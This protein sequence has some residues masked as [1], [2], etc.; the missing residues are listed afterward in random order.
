LLGRFE[1]SCIDPK[2]NISL[3]EDQQLNPGSG[4][5]YLMGGFEKNKIIIS[6][7][8]VQIL[9]ISGWAPKI[10]CIDVL[11]NIKKLDVTQYEKL[12]LHA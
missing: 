8:E 9:S 7:N 3:H 5:K 1:L 12:I 2:F 4:S 10:N 11:E 6:N